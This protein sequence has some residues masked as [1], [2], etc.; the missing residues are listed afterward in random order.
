VTLPVTVSSDQPEELTF[1]QGYEQ[2]KQIADRLDHDDV[3]VH[4]MCALF[5]RGK[6]LEQVLRDF[7]TEQQ[8]QL[9]AIERGENLPEF[10]I[11]AP[12][13]AGQA[14]AP[15]ETAGQT[16]LQGGPQGQRLRSVDDEIPF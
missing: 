1:E 5:A 11:V 6:G 14:P 16:S 4:E 2:L 10:R 7:L 9:E 12:P 3:P 15:V 8:G 13:P